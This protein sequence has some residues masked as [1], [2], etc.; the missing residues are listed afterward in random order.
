MR[1]YKRI[2]QWL[3][4]ELKQRDADG[5]VFGLSGGVDSS[6]VAAL[7]RKAV[8]STRTLGLILPCH[9]SQLDERDAR[10]IARILRI[11]TQ[12]IDL[13]KAY[14]ALT[15]LLPRA[16]QRA[17][18]NIKPRLRMIALYYFANKYNYLVCGTGNKAELMVGY[19]TKYGDG[20][21]DLLP[22]GGLLKRE[23]RQI[24]VELGIPADIVVKAP[25]AG[26]WKGQ[27]DEGEMGI[28]Y[29][30]LDDILKRM[31]RGQRQCYPR[32]KVDKV[33]RMIAQSQH[34]RILPDIGPC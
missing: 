27:T 26:L 1:R 30:E 2:V 34:K 20:G 25:S 29:D 32:K 11:K 22:I 3:R 5:F 15:A 4:R 8:G 10:R 33:K 16:S 24:A 21:V 17:K 14:D 7:C 19:F 18:A 9:S 31:N 12:K 23:V 6:V 13:C 28:T